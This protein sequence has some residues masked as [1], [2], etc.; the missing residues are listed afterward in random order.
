MVLH[1]GM[2][3]K[4]GPMA[5]TQQRQQVFLGEEI[6]RG[7][8][9]SEETAREVDEEVKSIIDGAYDRAF[10]TLRSHREALDRVA[11]Q[12]IEKEE[13]AGD[14]VEQLLGRD[15]GPPAESDEPGPAES[16]EPDAEAEGRS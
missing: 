8:E 1:W 2:S 12:L 14:E 6:A 9:Y 7:K 15:G 3:E 4:F 11:E 10:S 13:L 16:D 5:S